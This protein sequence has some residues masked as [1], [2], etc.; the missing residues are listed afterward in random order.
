MP[1][2]PDVPEPSSRS[3]GAA[4]LVGGLLLFLAIA[5]PLAAYIWESIN[6]LLSGIVQWRRLLITVAASAVFVIL[7]R[8]AGRL[9]ARWD[10][11]RR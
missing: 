10:D 3:R 4:G 7:L 1:T 8:V 5:T 6:Q 11:R 9:I 2:A